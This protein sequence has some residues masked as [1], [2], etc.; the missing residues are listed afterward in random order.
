[1][2]FDP[3]YL[4]NLLSSEPEF[5]NKSSNKDWNLRVNFEPQAMI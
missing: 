1:M 2:Q 3:F 5:A 4:D